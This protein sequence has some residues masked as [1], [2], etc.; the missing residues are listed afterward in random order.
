VTAARDSTFTGVFWHNFTSMVGAGVLGLPFAMGNLTWAGGLVTLAASW[1]VSYGT[2][3]ALVLMHEQGA[4]PGPVTRMDRYQE[5]TRFAFGRRAGN[6]AL[7][8]FQVCA[9]V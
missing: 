6:W 2:F 8:P 7:L 4:P 5:L 9:R 3:I 1:L